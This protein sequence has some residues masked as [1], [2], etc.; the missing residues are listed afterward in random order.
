MPT[1]QQRDV[2]FRRAPEADPPRQDQCLG[3][4]LDFGRLTHF[5]RRAVLKA[6]GRER[7]FPEIPSVGRSREPAPGFGS[8][9]PWIRGIEFPMPLGLTQNS[10][11]SPHLG[12]A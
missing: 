9:D 6:S 5:L 2:G 4:A 11:K 3:M 1:E 7:E 10:F 8:I 12:H